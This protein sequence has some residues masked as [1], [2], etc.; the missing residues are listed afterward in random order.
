MTVNPP[1]VCPKKQVVPPGRTFPLP[2]RPSY[3]CVLSILSQITVVNDTFLNVKLSEIPRGKN[4]QE[5]MIIYTE[6][7][8]VVLYLAAL[9]HRVHSVPVWLVAVMR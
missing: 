5:F 3:S 7:L 9:L 6:S 1:S 2:C 8:P 4:K